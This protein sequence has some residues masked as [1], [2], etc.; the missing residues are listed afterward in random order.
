MSAR[1]V[2]LPGAT[3]TT[4]RA[5]AAALRDAGH[6][7][8]AVGTDAERLAT[9]P[10]ASR[11]VADLVDAEQ[12][13]R[14]AERVLERHGRVDGLVHLIGGWK[15]GWSDETADWLNARLVTSL[16][17]ASAAFEPALLA[18]DAGRLA[19]VSSTA[20]THDGPPASA[21]AAAKLAAE[22]WVGQLATRWRETPA[23]AVTWVVRSLGD[24]EQDTA[25][26]VVAAA[27][28]D[29]WEAP[30]ASIAGARIRL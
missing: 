20:V 4:G 30:L 22:S 23:A 1:V 9:V 26:A 14:L 25:P 16:L 24:G 27:A 15:P 3:G 10:A 17:H 21:Y 18:S 12:A 7:V 29:L 13:A 19:I 2:V 6:E 5:V 8:V 28:V 11:E